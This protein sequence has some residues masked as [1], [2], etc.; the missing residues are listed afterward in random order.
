[1]DTSR[2]EYDSQFVINRGVR[3]SWD[4][5]FYSGMSHVVGSVWPMPKEI[6]DT[7]RR[8]EDWFWTEEWQ[9]GERAADEDIANGRYQEFKT[10]DELLSYLD[11][12]E[13]E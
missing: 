13:K 4:N 10:V 11:G 9:A 7:E 12:L 1:M 5:I 8:K 6:F 3:P 2:Y